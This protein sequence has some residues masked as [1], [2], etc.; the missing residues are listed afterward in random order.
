MEIL[1]I[2]SADGHLDY[3]PFWIL[4]KTLLWTFVYKFFCKHM[5][6]FLLGKYLGAELLNHMV[7]LCFT[8]WRTARLFSKVAISFYIPVSS[9]YEK[10]SLIK[11]LAGPWKCKE[12]RMQSVA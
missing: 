8:V 4:W 7:I 2:H 1:F 5:F 9:V 3:L 12:H 11:I 6:S 10:A